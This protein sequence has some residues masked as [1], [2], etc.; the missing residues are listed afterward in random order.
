MIYMLVL[1]K[2]SNELSLVVVGLIRMLVS[3]LLFT[4]ICNICIRQLQQIIFWSNLV[5]AKALQTSHLSYADSFCIYILN[6][7]N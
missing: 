3:K 2:V 6:Q 1:E 7:F 4:N 5:D